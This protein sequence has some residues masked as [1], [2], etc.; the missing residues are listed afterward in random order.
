MNMGIAEAHNLA[1]KLAAVHAGTA[2]PDLLDSYDAERHPVAVEAEK[3]AHV[4]TK[5]LTLRNPLLLKLRDTIFPLLGSLPKMRRKLPWMISGH[6]YRYRPSAVLQDSRPARAAK[7]QAARGLSAG[8][9]APDLELWRLKGDAPQRLLDLWQGQFALLLFTG[10]DASSPQGRAL[11]ELAQ[12]VQR[13]YPVIRPHLVVDAL[14]APALEP[15]VPVVLDADYRAHRRYGASGGELVL[16]RPDG[17]VAFTGDQPEALL[18]YLDARSGLTPTAGAPV[19]P[20]T[21]RRAS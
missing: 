15:A 20:L 6:R 17:F 2:R 18:Q 7:K 5:I 4:L 16:V 13:L 14:E 10:R 1:W 3:T 9:L 19:T 12:R 21:L 8:A 11:A